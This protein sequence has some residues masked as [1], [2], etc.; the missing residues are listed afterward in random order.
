MRRSARRA[1][2][3]CRH[4]PA[5]D[6]AASAPARADRGPAERGAW[7][8]DRSRPS[9]QNVPLRRSWSHPKR[10]A[11]CSYSSTRTSAPG[12]VQA[13][14]TT[15]LSRPFSTS[16]RR[17]RASSCVR[18]GRYHRSCPYRVAPDR[19][20]SRVPIWC[21]WHP[22]PDPTVHPRRCRSPRQPRH[23]EC[24]SQRSDVHAGQAGSKAHTR[25]VTA[26]GASRFPRSL[27]P[28]CS[29]P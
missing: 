8:P 1:A 11:N 20:P 15:A 2:A 12:D 17:S 22:L 21:P 5:L 28:G 25:T 6:P 27:Q 26:A 14:N 24:R 16:G 4:T 10:P 19:N 23:A 9:T 7:A 18:T 13:S 29:Q 3:P